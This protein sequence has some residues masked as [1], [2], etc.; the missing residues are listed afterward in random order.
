MD[1]SE[2]IKAT[3]DYVKRSLADYDSGHDWWH[4]DRVRRLALHINGKEQLCDPFVIEVAALMHD[5]ADSKF[6]G[7]DAGNKIACALIFLEENRME[8][9]RN[10]ILDV[11]ENVSFSSRGKSDQPTSQVVKIIQ[12]A[13]MLDAM[14]AIGIAR[15]FSYGGFRN[16]P[17]WDPD[18]GRMSTI[19]HF[20]DKLLKLKDLMNTETGRRVAAEKHKF[21]EY[22]LEQFYIEWNNKI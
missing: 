3:V 16:N 10:I 4:L 7:E 18:S 13:D 9:L 20:Y 2:K 1:K 15:A 14:G 12:D 19:Q 8:E 11:I 17:I 6:S 21:L 22:Y 5:I